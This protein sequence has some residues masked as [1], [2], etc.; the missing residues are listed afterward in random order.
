MVFRVDVPRAEFTPSSLSGFERIRVDGFGNTG[1]PAE[2]PVPTRTFLVAI[3]PEARFTVTARVIASEPFGVRRLE[4]YPTTIAIPG[5]DMGPLPGASIVMDDVVY[6]AW[7]PVPLVAP[8]EP[9][10]IRHQ[11]TL[12]I[13]VN[14]VSYDPASGELAMATRIEITVQLSG[15]MPRALEGQV[16]RPESKGWDETFGRLFVNAQQAA[17]WRLP[18]PEMSLAPLAAARVVPGAVKLRV[19]ETGMHRVTAANAIAAG[20]PAGQPTSNLRLFKRDYTESTFTGGTV[21]VAFTLREDPAGAT[22]VFDGNDLLIFYG[23]RLRDDASQNDVLEQYSQFNVYWL[24]PSAGTTMATRSPAAGF[25][26]ADTLTAAFTANLHFETDGVVREQPPLGTTDIYSL[27]FGFEP[28]PVDMP[29]ILNAIRPGTSLTLSA[30][31]FGQR[32]ASPRLLKVSLVN[33]KGEKVLD[34]AYSIPNKLRR[35]FSMVLPATD[36][37]IGTNRLR[38]DRPNT[39]RSTV[40]VQLNWV[41]VSGQFLYR[42]RGN[43]LRF[44]TATLAGD[45]SVTV[46]GLTTA[47]NIELFDITA[48]LTPVRMTI[49]PGSFQPVAGGF[50]LS[51][52]ENIPSQRQFAL[53]PVSGLIDIAAA[54]IVADQPSAIIG[55]GAEKGIDVLVVSH[56]TFMPQMQQWV[57]YRRAQGYRV[58]MVDVEDVFDEFNGGVPSPLAVFRFTRHFFENGSAGTLV[59]VGDGSEDHKRVHD[60]SGPNFVPAYARIDAVPSLAED[61][62]VSVDKRYVKMRAPNG[63]VDAYPDLVIGRIPVGSTGELEIVLDKT[64]KYE[65]PAASDFW[66]KR[67][68][69][70]SDDAYS[71]G[72]SSFGNLSQFC[73]QPAEVGFRNS[74]EA[75]AQIIENSLPAGYDVIRFHLG[76]YTDSFYTTNCASRTAAISFTRQNVTELLLNALNQGATWVTVQSHMNRSLMTHESLFATYSSSVLDGT[77]GRDHLR[78]ENRGKPWVMFG[79]GCHFSEYGIHRELESRRTS[80]NNPNGDAFAEQLLFQNDRGA[81]GT[82]GSTGFEY[83]Q[84]NAIMMET[85]TRVWFYEA[86]YDTMVNQTKGEWIFGDLM[87]LT[88]AQLAGTQRDPV[89][90]YLILG[91]PLLRIDA[92]PPAFNVTVDGVP[93][94]TGD[95]VTAGGEGDTILVEATVTDENAIRDFRLEIDGANATDLLTVTPLVDGT[96]PRA[97]QYR[98]SF[99]HKLR[100]ENYDIV[101][102]AY[103][104]PDTLAGQYHM[105]AEFTLRVESSISV[106]VNGREIASGGAVPATGNYRIDL[107]FPVFV[108]ESAI[109]ISIDDDVVNDAVLAH[110]SPEDSLKWVATFRRTLGPGRHTLKVQAGTIE[111][112]YA[113]VVS[114]SP[115]LHNVINYPNPFRGEGTSIVYTND[116]EITGGTIEIFTVSGKRI[117]RL[118]IPPQARFPGQNAVFWDGR[119]AAGGAIANGTYLYVIRVEQRVGSSTTRGKMARIE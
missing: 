84:P 101:L 65:A 88:E 22:G 13:R 102:R 99:R 105:A 32:Y 56:A 49:D 92:G 89:E 26:T 103:Q 96:V 78:V 25:V 39:L 74:Q 28:G 109:E 93:F 9:V 97:R 48:P 116:V 20:F 51:F 72:G 4:P 54:D 17:G 34:G 85:T 10:Y 1:N 60:D 36:F 77:T 117:R 5:E 81:V 113:L 42:A 79:L 64:F 80:S 30:E 87:F 3:P 90:R 55:S 115:G 7:Q 82:Y 50:A 67:M 57:S 73:F 83:L 14:P 118:D 70:V 119:D 29:F 69:V 63:T 24:E 11:R 46:T 76:D 108:P 59:L 52:R 16:A 71:E 37:D 53:I 44:N 104:S 38:I 62:V 91:D 12:P 19:R 100:P 6:R 8:E 95:I 94:D 68:I 23:R 43:A 18:R 66:R 27:N 110:P 112:I 114:D 107:G 98:V 35:L 31:M 2:P 41:E 33:S 111:L 45:T 21:D 40:E 86:P 47:S 106:S 61:E 15:T 58:Y 75:S